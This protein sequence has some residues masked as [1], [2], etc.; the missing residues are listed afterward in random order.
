MTTWNSDPL[1]YLTRSG[2]LD[3]PFVQISESFK[4]I[5]SKIVLTE[6]P[7]P[8][9]RVLVTNFIETNSSAPAQGYFQTDYYNGILTFNSTDEGTIVNISYWGKGVTFYPYKRVWTQETNGEVVQTLED[10]VDD[11]I[12]LLDFQIGLI[13]GTRW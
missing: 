11:T 2:T 13:Y 6:I 7:D 10:L 12:S 8:I 5:N 9:N 3:D 4:I 1:I